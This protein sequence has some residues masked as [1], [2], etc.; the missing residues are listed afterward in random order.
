MRHQRVRLSAATGLAMLLTAC[1]GGADNQ[2]SSV[3]PNET[4]SAVS[5]APVDPEATLASLKGDAANGEKVFARCAA[6]HSVVPKLNM[7]GPSLFGVVGR[8]SGKAEGYAY[9]QANMASG[10]VWSEEMLF[11][12]LKDPRAVMPGTKMAFAGL[13]N[14]QER[15]DVIAYMATKK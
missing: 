9:S 5:T 6:C 10:N 14:P 2:A 3:A 4:Q 8:Q 15:A 13:S 11:K 12:Y 1:S 7:V